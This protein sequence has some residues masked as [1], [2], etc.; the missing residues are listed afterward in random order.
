MLKFCVILSAPVS[1]LQVTV[2]V[3]DLDDDLITTKTEKLDDSTYDEMAG[4]W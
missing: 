2:N 3:L 4:T 1:Y